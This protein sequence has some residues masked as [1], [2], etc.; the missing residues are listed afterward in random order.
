MKPEDRKPGRC[1]INACPGEKFQLSTGVWVC[2]A[3]Y[4]SPMH[5]SSVMRLDTQAAVDADLERY[6]GCSV[7]QYKKEVQQH[8]KKTRGR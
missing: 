1:N 2:P 5:G 8:L 6:A 3:Y 7:E 4:G